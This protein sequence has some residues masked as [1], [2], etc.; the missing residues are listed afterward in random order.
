MKGNSAVY[1]SDT[2]GGNE[3]EQSEKSKLRD[4][5]DSSPDNCLL[6]NRSLKIIEFNKR[7]AYSAKF[8]FSKHLCVGISISEF[9]IENAYERFFGDLKK[10]FKGD[11]VVRDEELV[12][13]SK[14]IWF[15]FRFLPVF[16]IN[17]RVKAVTFHAID[18]SN[19]KKHKKY[20]RN[21]RKLFNQGPAVAFKWTPFNKKSVTKYV[22]PNVEKVFGYEP[23]DLIGKSFQELIHPEDVKR[24]GRYRD[25]QVAQ[26]VR[27]DN[28]FVDSSYRVKCAN[29]KYRWFS[30]YSFLAKESDGTELVYG[31][32]IDV[33]EQKKITKELEQKN[34]QLNEALTTAKTQSKI[35]EVTTSMIM[36]TDINGKISWIN[37]AVVKNTGYT[38]NEAF[39]KRPSELFAGPET[40]KDT[41]ERV[42]AAVKKREK[43]SV[44]MINYKK[45]GDKFWVELKT[46]PIFDEANNL[47]AYLSIQSD[48]SDRKEMEE[49]LKYRN[50]QLKKFSFTTSHELRHEFAKILSL[51]ENK[52]L[53]METDSDLDILEE[54]STATKTMNTI[55][56][57]MNEQLLISDSQNVE[58]IRELSLADVDEICLIDDDDIVCFINRKMIR[59]VLP[60]KK[61]EIFHSADE[62]LNY[63]KSTP[64]TFKRYIFLDL[65]MP[66]KSGWDFLEEYKTLENQSPVIILTSSIDSLDRENAKKF[67]E[68]VSFFSKPLKSD[69]IESLI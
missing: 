25:T 46:E 24:I 28:S 31:Y 59:S 68:V 13:P 65:N 30:D 55:I 69:K 51:L 3:D 42:R 6:I 33:S 36:F 4:I 20:L 43:I 21:E 15:Q 23:E 27:T 26:K 48:I 11:V 62:A 47:T 7:A 67:P 9:Y 49:K 61:I 63:F 29:G 14:I 40:D 64:S 56:S 60:D 44:E 17:N 19:F 41:M 18:I 22:S 38:L 52:D 12:L 35:L 53:L 45:N 10:A 66:I 37:E 50:E 39:N 34:K 2:N 54:V 8:L 16:D 5:V 57:K 1:M 58:Q 32:L